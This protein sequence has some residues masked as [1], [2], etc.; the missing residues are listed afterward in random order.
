VYEKTLLDYV[1]LDPPE[2]RY[3]ANKQK[4]G[5][6]IAEAVRDHKVLKDMPQFSAYLAWGAPTSIDRPEGTAVERWTYDTPN[7]KG[8]VDFLAGKVAKF[9]GENIQDTEA[10][11][12]KR[13]V[14]R[15]T[16]TTTAAEKK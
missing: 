8:R 14:R 13:A 11:K 9:E 10:A 15:G 16:T 4:Y 1:W 5:T 7:I 12:K 6:R 3:D 2:Q